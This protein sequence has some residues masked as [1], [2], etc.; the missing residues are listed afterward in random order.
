MT[1]VGTTD[2]DD[3]GSTERRLKDPTEEEIQSLAAGIRATWSDGKAESR[4]VLP[5]RELWHPPAC[6]ID[7]ESLC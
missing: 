4:W 1:I 5:G 2:A 7:D 6:A 3:G